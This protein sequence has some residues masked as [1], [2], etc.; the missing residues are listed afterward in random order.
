MGNFDDL[1]SDHKKRAN[2]IVDKYITEYQSSKDERSITNLT[3]YM[4]DNVEDLC[5]EIE[6]SGNEVLSYMQPL[7]PDP[8][9]VYNIQE[10]N[11]AARVR[12]GDAI[13][14]YLE[15]LE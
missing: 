5:T 15:E 11:R 1:L 13:K 4:A 2:K 12:W 8:D 7:N 3:H 10:I 14:K 9:Q 6:N